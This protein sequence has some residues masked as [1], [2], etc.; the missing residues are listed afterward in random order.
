MKK[1]A[2]ALLCAGLVA[3][4][5]PASAFVD[6]VRIFG[7]ANPAVDPFYIPEGPSSDGGLTFALPSNFT[8]LASRSTVFELPDEDDPTEFEEVGTL[9]DVVL[10][11]STDGKL[12]FGSRIEMDINEEGEINDIYRR[13]FTGWGASFGWLAVTANDLRLYSAGR[14]TGSHLSDDDPDLP[15]PDTLAFGT[16]V[17]VEELNPFTAWYLA[18]TDAPF[19]TL[20]DD[21]V[22]VFQA[23]EEDQAPFLVNMAGFAP[24]AVPVPAALPLMLSGLGLIALRRRQRKD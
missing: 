2:Q 3:T 17:N 23:G 22:G 10:R 18:K 1:A 19:F 16:D 15:D 21:A 20:M 6:G 12:V 24:T 9:F 14:T 7:S 11:D 4:A 13:G 8:V 5:L